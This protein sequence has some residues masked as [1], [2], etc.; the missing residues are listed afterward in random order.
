MDNEQVRVIYE[1][2]E[3]CILWVSGDVTS[4]D[5]VAHWVGGFICPK[6]DINGLL[7]YTSLSTAPAGAG[8]DIIAVLSDDNSHPSVF[9]G[10]INNWLAKEGMSNE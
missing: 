5:Q 6:H 7:Q 8:D 1:D 3:R 2:E 10:T 9:Q 4:I